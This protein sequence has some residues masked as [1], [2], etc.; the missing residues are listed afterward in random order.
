MSE[1]K[2]MSITLLKL[3]I[4]L[5]ACRPILHFLLSHRRVPH[6]EVRNLS[7]GRGAAVLVVEAATEIQDNHVDLK[8]SGTMIISHSMNSPPKVRFVEEVSR[9]CDVTKFWICEVDVQC[10][11]IL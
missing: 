8:E 7:L 2:L 11:P 6:I 9:N 4:H 1:V 10:P 3:I 5:L